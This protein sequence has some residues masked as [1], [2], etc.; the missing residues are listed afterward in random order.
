[1]NSTEF[2]QIAKFLLNI[3]LIFIVMLHFAY[4]TEDVSGKYKTWKWSSTLLTIISINIIV[5]IGFFIV[6]VKVRFF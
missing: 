6:A 5:A 3:A 2:L 1:M 4:S